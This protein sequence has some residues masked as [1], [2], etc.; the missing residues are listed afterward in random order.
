MLFLIIVGLILLFIKPLIGA[1]YIAG[2][3]MAITIGLVAKEETNKKN[4]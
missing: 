4:K 3:L 2:V 1:I